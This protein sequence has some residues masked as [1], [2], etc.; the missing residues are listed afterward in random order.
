MRRLGRLLR[1]QGTFDRIAIAVLA[2][3]AVVLVA[4]LAGGSDDPGGDRAVRLVPRDALVYVHARVEP[5]SEQ[6][7]DAGEVVRKL[8]TLSRLR[9]RA[10]RALSRGDRALDFDASVRP[11]IGDEAAL[12]LLPEGSAPA[13]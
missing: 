12:A 2:L 5:N 11:W 9:R 13:L 4:S 7:R 8:P 1:A 6:W 3:G 10:L